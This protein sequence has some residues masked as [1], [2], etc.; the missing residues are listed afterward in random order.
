MLFLIF[1][2]IRPHG[3][4][5]VPSKVWSVTTASAPQGDHENW[6]RLPWFGTHGNICTQNG[7]IMR[8]KSSEKGGV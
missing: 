7:V 3:K 6:Q 4:I 2:Q 5:I 8:Q 1:F